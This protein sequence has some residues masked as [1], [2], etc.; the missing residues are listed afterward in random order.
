MYCF[1]QC[2]LADLGSPGRGN[3]SSWDVA[4]ARE[5]VKL[6]EI[7]LLCPGVHSGQA[8]FQAE[9]IEGIPAPERHYNIQD[10]KIVLSGFSDVVL[11]HD[12]EELLNQSLFRMPTPQEQEQMVQQ[13]QQSGTIQESPELSGTDI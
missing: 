2:Y 5:S 8:A 4:L 13:A 9:L 6:M 10:G 3:Q 7:V 12:A 1:S 11:H